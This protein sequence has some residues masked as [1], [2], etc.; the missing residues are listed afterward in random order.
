MAR[1]PVGFRLDVDRPE[2]F[3]KACDPG[4]CRDEVVVLKRPFGGLFGGGRSGLNLFVVLVLG[5]AHPLRKAK[6]A[7]DAPERRVYKATG[8]EQ[9]AD[10]H[11]KLTMGLATMPRALERRMCKATGKATGRHRRQADNGAGYSY[12][13]ATATLTGATRKGLSPNWPVPPRRASLRRS[14]QWS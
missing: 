2:L 3:F 10:T 12:H 6:D 4:D 11:A 8:K 13:T 5:R 1:P 9:R 7:P 14:W